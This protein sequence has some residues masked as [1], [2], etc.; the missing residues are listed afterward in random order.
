MKESNEFLRSIGGPI[1]IGAVD[2]MRTIRD[3][4][5]V[6]DIIDT[7]FADCGTE[8]ESGRNE[9]PVEP[10]E[11]V[12]DGT[13]EQMFTSLSSDLNKICFVQDQIVS[14]CQE[15]PEKLRGDDYGTYF[16]LKTASG[17]SVVVVLA[18]PKGSPG[19]FYQKFSLRIFRRHL[20]EVVYSL[21][22]PR[23]MVPAF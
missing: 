2:G 21:S 17:F 23:V 20:G 14:F 11:L 19:I 13:F 6:F 16:L 8:P 22:R 9:M 3:A 15:H 4:K 7:D 1:V 12:K 10:K 18:Y 5:D